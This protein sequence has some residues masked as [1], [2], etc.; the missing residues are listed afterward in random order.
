MLIVSRYF[1]Y[2]LLFFMASPVVSLTCT[3]GNLMS[4]LYFSFGAKHAA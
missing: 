4:R 3:F 2:L 1:I